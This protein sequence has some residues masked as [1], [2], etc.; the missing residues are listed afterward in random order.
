M[1]TNNEVISDPLKELNVIAETQSPS[2]EQGAY[3]LRKL[4]EMIEA[5]AET[6]G[7]ELGYFAQTLTTDNCPV[8]DWALRAVKACL[9]PKIASH[10]GA[11]VSPELAVEIDQAYSALLR[12]VMSDSL[13]PADMSH[14]PAGSAGGDSFDIE[15]GW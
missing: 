7:I 10:Y 6:D 1:A 2:P 11:S 8:P 9:A 13:R 14:M 5:W 12:K 3:C 15:R 4:N